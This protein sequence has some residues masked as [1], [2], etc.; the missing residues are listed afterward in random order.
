MNWL[1]L[2][3]ASHIHEKRKFLSYKYYDGIPISI[4]PG[5]ARRVG[6]GVVYRC[7]YM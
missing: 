2:C 1:V 5:D 7:I 3:G 4:E 6:D